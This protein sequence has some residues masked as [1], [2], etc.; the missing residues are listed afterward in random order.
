V[1]ELLESKRIDREYVN[2]AIIMN[3]VLKIF[4]LTLSLYMNVTHVNM[5]CINI[6]HWI[7][8]LTVDHK[9]NTPC[10][11]IFNNS[12]KRFLVDGRNG[13]IFTRS[14]SGHF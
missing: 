4:S 1:S 11:N 3:V 6:I 10:S 9:V 12:E 7:D 14:V 8:T 5:C 2:T 13:N